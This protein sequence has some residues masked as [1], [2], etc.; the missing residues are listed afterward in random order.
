MTV[1][2]NDVLTKEGSNTLS[3]FLP[4]F[5]EVREDKTQADDVERIHAMFNAAKG[6]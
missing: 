5:V 6:V 4:V 3:L 1:T 2:A